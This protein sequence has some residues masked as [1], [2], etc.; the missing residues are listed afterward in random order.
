M[1]ILNLN[2]NM[3]HSFTQNI[4][5]KRKYIE[6]IYYGIELIG[7]FLENTKYDNILL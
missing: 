1:L 4:Y 6:T 5:N 3:K 2:S 7:Q